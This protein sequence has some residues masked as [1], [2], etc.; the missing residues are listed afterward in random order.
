MWLK[1]LY[2]YCPPPQ[3]KIFLSESLCTMFSWKNLSFSQPLL[4]Q[5][6]SDEFA[7]CTTEIHL[8]SDSSSLFYMDY[9]RWVYIVIVCEVSHCIHVHTRGSLHTSQTSHL[10]LYPS[11]WLLVPGLSSHFCCYFLYNLLLKSVQV[12]KIIRKWPQDFVSLGNPCIHVHAW[13][14]VVQNVMTDCMY[15][16]TQQEVI[17][18]LPSFIKLSPNLVK[19]VF[20]KLLISFKG[21]IIYMYMCVYVQCNSLIPRPIP[22]LSVLLRLGMGLGM[23]LHIILIK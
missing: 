16:Y 13:N 23:R 17:S 5:S 22:S 12:S 20:D 7:N 18:A 19:G 10:L 9:R 2:S 3:L 1:H 21:K 11:L 6:W 4:H 15:L 8:M 14:L